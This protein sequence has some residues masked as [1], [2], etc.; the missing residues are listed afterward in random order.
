[1]ASRRHLHFCCLQET[2]WRGEGART[3]GSYKFLWTGCKK[4]T[5]EIGFLAEERWVD[6]VLEVKRVSERIM[7]L[8]VRV[9]E[10]VL[11]LVSVYAPQ[12]GRAIEDK[13]EF[14]TSLG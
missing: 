5:A 6:R 12:V 9:G 13:E 10:T 2:R 1:M 11:N 4:G 3:F 14:F 7:V 8:K